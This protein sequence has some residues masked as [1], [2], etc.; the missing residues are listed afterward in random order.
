MTRISP[1]Q[2]ICSNPKSLADRLRER[3]RR[4]GPI[5]F[6]DWM[7]AALYDESEGYYCRPGRVRQGRSGDYRTAPET[8]SLFAVTF[9]CYFAKL[10]AELG[11]PSQFTIVEAG[12]GS[13]Q[14]AE[15][16]L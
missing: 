4:E 15:G 13:G 9:A 8:S 1:H 3:I 5:S 6:Y 7:Q 10:F 11:S 16:V 14:F 2:E 12:A